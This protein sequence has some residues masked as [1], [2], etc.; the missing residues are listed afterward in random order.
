MFLS[1][2]EDSKLLIAYEA[3][4]IV[5]VKMRPLFIVAVFLY[6]KTDSYHLRKAKKSVIVIMIEND[7]IGISNQRH[8]N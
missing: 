3:I 8:F 7:M 6:K 4:L 5:L 2:L 1:V